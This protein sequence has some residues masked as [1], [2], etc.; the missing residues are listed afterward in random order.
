[1]NPDSKH[2]DYDLYIVGIDGKNEKALTDTDYSQGLACR[3]NSGDKLAYVVA[4]IEG[5]GKYDI[6]IID[7]DGNN[8]RNV[9][10]EYFPDGFLCHSPVFS[11]D[12][13]KIYF[14]G[15]WWE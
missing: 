1:V 10:P 12:D 3:S 15:Q 9:T 13:T 7:S 14:I 2:G 6:Y 8:N 11:E 5:K 4:A